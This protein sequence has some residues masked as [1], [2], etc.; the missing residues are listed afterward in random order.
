MSHNIRD[1]SKKETKVVFI[2][3]GNTCRS[4]MAEGIFRAINSQREEKVST[5]AISRGIHAYEGDP[6][7]EHSIK[8]LQTLWDIDISLHKAKMLN[9]NDVKQADLLL[10]MTRQHRNVLRARYS[11]RADGIFTLKEFAYPELD[12]NSSLLDI[13]DPFGMPYR[14]YESCAQEIYECIKIVLDKLK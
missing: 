12:V 7:S 1:S 13:S 2:C 9:E 14:I 10:T 5:L 11:D 3:T 8:A 4:C 6:A